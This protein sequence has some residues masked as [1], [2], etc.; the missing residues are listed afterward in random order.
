MPPD[1]PGPA[2][3]NAAM[4][5]VE[6]GEGI[7]TTMLS[8]LLVLAALAV[9]AQS[10]RTAGQ[11]ESL[12]SAVPGEGALAGS[13]A[14]S[15]ALNVKIVGSIGGSVQAVD[16]DGSNAYI[17][18]EPDLVILDVADLHSPTL[19]GR[20]APLPDQVLD[21]AASGGYA[22]VAAGAAGLRV[23]D[24]RDPAHPAEV[25]SY[26]VPGYIQAVAVSGDYA[27]LADK[28]AGLRVVDVRDPVH[29]AEV[30]FADTPFFAACQPAPSR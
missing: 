22:Y 17:G 27:Y 3:F 12:R 7:V 24:G 28:E 18:E 4:N 19:A 16:V 13:A 10:G 5:C 23:V 29:P 11:S 2:E 25:G 6:F 9:P 20:S 1:R 26:T 14:G 30:G 8:L 21:V 15:N